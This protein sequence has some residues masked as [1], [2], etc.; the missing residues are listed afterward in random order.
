MER[1]RKKHICK[2]Q[3]RKG[4]SVTRNLI[5][6]FKNNFSVALMIDQR[7]SEGENVEFFNRTAKTTTI[8][9]QFV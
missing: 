9:A 4:K 5:D 8:P 2:N 7:V 1:I 6:L 3:I